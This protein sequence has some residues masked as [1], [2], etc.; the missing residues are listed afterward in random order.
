[1][2]D[3][4]FSAGIE[5]SL[6]PWL[7]RVFDLSAVLV[8]LALVYALGG[9][10]YLPINELVLWGLLAAL[11][12]IYMAEVFSH[13]RSWRLAPF[14][15]VVVTT[16]LLWAAVTIVLVIALYFLKLAE[17]F[18]RIGFAYWCT[19]TATLLVAWRWA[20]R[21]YQ[22]RLRTQGHNLKTALVVGATPLGIELADAL[23]RE[24]EVGVRV[25]G[26]Y[27]DRDKHRLDS[28]VQNLVIGNVDDAL[29]R[30]ER[31]GIDQIFVALPLKAEDRISAILQRCANTTSQVHIVPN[32]FVY[33][34]VNAAWCEVGGIRTLSV[35]ESPIRGPWGALKRAEDLTIATI[36]LLVFAIPMLLIALAIRL[37]SRGPVLFKQERYG[38]DGRKIEVWKFRSMT[39]VENGTTIKQAT[40]NDSRI[41]KIGAFIRRTSLDELP[42]FINVL[43][44]RMSV[45]GPRPHAVA[46]NEQYRALIQGYML[47]HKVKPG[48]TGWAQVNGWRG[49][50]DTLDKMARRVEHDMHYITHWSVVLDIQILFLTLR[51]GFV[52]DNAY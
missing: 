36:A 6:P 34:L 46:H 21:R 33:N 16:L 30:A 43:Q 27:D 17:N 12:M 14:S 48:I 45:V 28:S 23:A 50:T 32:F 47:R 1:M 4:E 7:A 26:F 18:G 44:G 25:L 35:Y 22:A 49:E 2:T 39:C 37:E 19:V 29:D 13:Y 41:T 40:R 24:P 11:L 20:V 8:G 31:G 15:E 5:G 51:K 38:V 9:P 10:L 42:Q 3:K 52:H